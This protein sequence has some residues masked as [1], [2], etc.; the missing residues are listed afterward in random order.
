MTKAQKIW[1]WVSVAMFVVPE[2]LWSPVTNFLYSLFTPTLNGYSKVFRNNFLFDYKY[3]N[4]LQVILLVQLVGITIFFFSWM[5]IKK[6]AT[7]MLMF[8]IIFLVSLFLCLI[9]LFT[10]YLGVVLNI[11][12]P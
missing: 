12:F 6:S 1:L 9:S 11:S 8:W 2:V 10:F 5:R 7:S 4:L 3:E